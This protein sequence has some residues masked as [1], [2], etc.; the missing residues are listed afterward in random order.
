MLNPASRPRLA[1]WAPWL[2]VL[3]AVTVLVL[4]LATVQSED[5][6]TDWMIFPLLASITIYWLLVKEWAPREKQG[7][8]FV[9]LW[10]FLLGIVVVAAGQTGE[11]PD[12][13][14]SGMLMT[15]LLVSLV[16]L[17]LCLSALF[18]SVRAH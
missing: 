4:T 8:F 1:R 9:A 16:F 7:P 15:Q 2:F 12:P 13:M 18:S 5:K 6:M 10:A 17:G 11:P 3:P 14:S